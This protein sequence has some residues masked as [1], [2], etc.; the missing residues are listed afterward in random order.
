MKNKGEKPGEQEKKKQRE[1]TKEKSKIQ[2]RK[3]IFGDEYLFFEGKDG[4]PK[5]ENIDEKWTEIIDWLETVRERNKEK[6]GFENSQPDLIGQELVRWAKKK[7]IYPIF[8]ITK[9]FWQVFR[10]TY[11]VEGHPPIFMEF[12]RNIMVNKMSE[13]EMW[14]TKEDRMAKG[15]L[16][17]FDERY[18]PKEEE[19]RQG[20]EVIYRL[21]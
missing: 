12:I 13:K 20:L 14:G 16:I 11:L 3:V 2:E 8:L 19:K 21:G 1:N 6:E 4:H 9:G 5:Y 7:D 15:K 10:D 18:L 17:I